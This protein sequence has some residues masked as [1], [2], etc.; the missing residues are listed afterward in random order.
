[1][2]EF[3]QALVT[4]FNHFLCYG[5]DSTRALYNSDSGQTMSNSSDQGS[6]HGHGHYW[7]L[8][9]KYFSKEFQSIDYL[10]KEYR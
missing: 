7:D 6:Q 2:D 1:M 8:I 5:F 10:N 4:I 9:T 3:A